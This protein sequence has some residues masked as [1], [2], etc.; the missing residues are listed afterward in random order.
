MKIACGSCA[1]KYTVSDDKIQG[2]AVKVKC[3][4]CG[5]VIV[6]SPNGEVTTQGGTPPAPLVTYTVSVTDTD[7][8]S[9]AIADVI[10]AYNDGTIDAETFVWTEGMG[11]WAPLK[12]V[13]ALV[14]ALH[15]A[16]QG[17]PAAP[18]EAAPP[19]DL[20]QTMAM[21]DGG[22]PDYDAALAAQRDGG[23]PAVA[24]PA[25][26]YPAA[27]YPA[28]ASPAAGY[29]AVASPAAVY[30]AAGYPAVASPAAGYPAVA[31]PAAGYPAA[32]YPAAPAPA[33]APPAEDELNSTVAMDGSAAVKLFGGA[34]MPA[35]R[36]AIALAPTATGFGAPGGSMFGGGGGGM[37]ANVSSGA[38][39]PN[40]GGDSSSRGDDGNSAIFSLNTLTANAA[41][42]PV[43]PKSFD[44][45]DSGL[46]DLKALA[47]G[48]G[49]GADVPAATAMSGDGGL[50]PLAG[51]QPLAPPVAMAMAAPV[52][53][54]VAKPSNK[55]VMGALAAAVV[56]LLG[57]V[58][59]LAVRGSSTPTQEVAGSSSSAPSQ[60][61]IAA[62]PADTSTSASPAA[63]A[64]TAPSAEVAVAAAPSATSEAAVASTPVAAQ[65]GGPAAA[66]PV[67]PP[68]P[69]AGAGAGATP[70][71][72]GAT[73]PP[74]PKSNSGG[75]AP[76]DLMCL[77][78]AGAKKR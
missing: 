76:D 27:G 25:A 78:R 61:A 14:D 15:E 46:I 36:P 19:N 3:R 38:T 35:P 72:A 77:M 9:M 33:Y 30:P 12:D 18:A 62:K 4:K 54:E 66:R 16:A 21:P 7:Q 11:D 32:G 20:G 13:D 24:S 5:A 71:G 70:A 69:A 29:P 49:G 51:L 40:F 75:C 26:V 73:K 41:G 68:P 64:T 23:F 8:R 44:Q 53:V 28:V 43:R 59:F 2:K 67:A 45:E 55:G 39:A 48:F 31:S 37:F 10:A 63:A 65:Y 58:I 34:A 52:I 57:A 50:F 74:P 22:L 47:S 6:V 60:A 1:A 56:L 42:V 17:S